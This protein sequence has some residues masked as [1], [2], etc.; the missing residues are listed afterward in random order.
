[1]RLVPQVAAASAELDVVTGGV[2]G[3]LRGI[4]DPG[5]VTQRDVPDRYHRYGPVTGGPQRQENIGSA[6]AVQ[7]G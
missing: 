3:S 7:G 6:A 4:L 5:P 1:M 2:L